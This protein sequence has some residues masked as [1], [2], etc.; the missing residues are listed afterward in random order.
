MQHIYDRMDLSDVTTSALSATTLVAMIGS[1]LGLFHVAPA[2]LAQALLNYSDWYTHGI[3]A[4]V[5]TVNG[6]L[7]WRKIKRI[8]RNKN[9]N[10]NESTDES[11]D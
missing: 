8:R 7:L 11:T 4:I 1:F 3:G 10:S 6:Y 9:N 5:V 2:S